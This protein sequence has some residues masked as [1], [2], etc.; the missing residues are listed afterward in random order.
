MKR[1]ETN[2]C[3]KCRR[4]DKNQKDKNHIGTCTIDGTKVPDALC[5]CEHFDDQTIVR[6]NF[7]NR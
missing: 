5:W 7:T 2:H 3:W 1:T 6:Y 4:L